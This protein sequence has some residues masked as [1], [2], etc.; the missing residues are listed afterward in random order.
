[1]Y[2]T[3]T[4]NPALDLWARIDST[5]QKGNFD[6]LGGTAFT[7]LGGKGIN[8]SRALVRRGARSV[9]VYAMRDLD[10]V[11]AQRVLKE[12]GII[13]HRIPGGKLRTTFEIHFPDGRCAE[14][15]P[16]ISEGSAEAPEAALRYFNEHLT[17]DDTVF[18]SGSLPGG[19]PADT[20]VRL[21]AACKEKG[22][23]VILDTAGEP[24]RL[25]VT[26]DVKPDLVKP[27][28]KEFEELT[29]FTLP[30]P[31]ADAPLPKAI[32]VEL[33]PDEWPPRGPDKEA[34]EAARFFPPR[35]EMTPGSVEK[36][37]VLTDAAQSFALE[38]GIAVLLTLGEE[39]AVYSDGPGVVYVP[40]VELGHGRKTVSTRGAGDTYLANFVL[41]LDLTGDAFRAMSRAAYYAAGH[42][43]AI[44][45]DIPK[46]G[47]GCHSRRSSGDSF[48]ANR[49]EYTE[50]MVW[51]N[52]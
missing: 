39:G 37:D 17:K 51:P 29:G 20:Y 12:E 13:P 26:A 46:E 4:L 52:V 5:P 35:P 8:V 1:M 11:T 49:D 42:V 43:S 30:E 48:T 45:R 25:A 47:D 50:E 33:L 24:L 19:T 34:R 9:A 21:I 32:N 18:L 2:Y 10:G 3:L 28:L 22:A 16:P 44:S 27:N 41:A 15:L 38:T 31:I 40:A 36:L 23:R 6:S 14:N 7:T